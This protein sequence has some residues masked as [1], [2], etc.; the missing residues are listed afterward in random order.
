MHEKLD[1]WLYA[2]LCH[3]VP[4]LKLICRKQANDQQGSH[5]WLISVAN[6]EEEV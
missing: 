5:W 3:T 4:V 2:V 1:V 6:E